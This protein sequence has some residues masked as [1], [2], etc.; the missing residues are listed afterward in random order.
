MAQ[1]L[2]CFLYKHVNLSSDPQLPHLKL[3]M[4]LQSQLVYCTYLYACPWRLEVNVGYHP[5]L[6]F[7]LTF[8]TSSLIRPGAH[9]VS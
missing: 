8:E 2:K 5:Q 9:Q 7:I 4:C 6:L 1:S 3:D